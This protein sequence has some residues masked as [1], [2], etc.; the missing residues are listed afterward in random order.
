MYQKFQQY[1]RKRQNLVAKY[2]SVDKAAAEG[3]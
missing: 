2:D 3:Y 1:E